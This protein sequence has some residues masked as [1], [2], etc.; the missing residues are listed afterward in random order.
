M[1][2]SLRISGYKTYASRKNSGISIS[3]GSAHIKLVRKASAGMAMKLMLLAAEANM[4]MP[5]IHQGIFRSPSAN[6][7]LP[8]CLR[9][10]Y[11]PANATITKY[12]GQ[13]GVI[14][15]PQALDRSLD[16]QI[17]GRRSRRTRSLPTKTSLPL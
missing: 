17:I 14:R 7:S 15:P 2:S 3:D 8:V 4:E 1:I 6:P 11:S 13:S 16:G 10:K 9:V 5:A 12:R